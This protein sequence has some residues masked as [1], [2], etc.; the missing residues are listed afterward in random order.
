MATRTKISPVAK[1]EELGEE[2]SDWNG[3]MD[4]GSLHCTQYE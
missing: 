3:S 2:G 4:I 1:G